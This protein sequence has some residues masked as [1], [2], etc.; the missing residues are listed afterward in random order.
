MVEQA[1][2]AEQDQVVEIGSNDGTLLRLFQQAGMRVL[3]VDP[4]REIA[5]AATDSGIKTVPDFFTPLLAKQLR[6]DGWRP[7]LIAA[8]NVFAHAD[9]L[10]GIAESVAS[11]L[12]PEGL[13]VFEVSYLVDVVEKTLFDTIYHEHLSYHSLKPLIGFLAA[14]GLEVVESMRVDSHGGSLRVMSRPKGQ[15]KPRGASVETLLALEARM[16]LDRADAFKRLF[17]QIQDRKAELTRVLRES[18]SAKRTVAG[19]GAPAKATTLMFHFGLGPETLKYIV[20]DSPLKQ[21]RFSPGH[22]IPVVPSAHLY[23]PSTKPDDVL[24]LAWNFAG[25]I[26]HNHRRFTEQ[27]GR[28]IV[29]LPQVVVR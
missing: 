21:G 16:G 22:H 19:F 5:N 14:H 9:D 2:L 6:Q 7:K 25:P 10:H 3:G 28:F 23:Q 29:P 17:T 4:A 24:I 18:R 12:S 1:G 8:N 27:G 26:M 11:L 20:D 13:F 15:G